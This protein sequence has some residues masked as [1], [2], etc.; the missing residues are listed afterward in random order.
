M[1]EEMASRQTTTVQVA[2]WS[3][4]L[5]S[6]TAKAPVGEG[7]EL[8]DQIRALEELKSA[9]AAAQ[10]RA[11]ARFA[12]AQRAEQRAAGMPTAGLGRGVAAQVALAGIVP[13]YARRPDGATLVV[14]GVPM[15]EPMPTWLVSAL[16]GRLGK[17][18]AAA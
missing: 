5:R 16:G 3:A 11:T 15:V 2:G 12:A 17:P 7:A 10:A 4:A 14:S 6:L 9:A 1:F 13:L 8:I 18:R